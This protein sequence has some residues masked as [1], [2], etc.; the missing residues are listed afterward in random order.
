MTTVK[1]VRFDIWCARCKH[2]KKKETERPC[3]RC[4]SYPV[5]DSSEKPVEYEERGS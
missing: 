2:Q 4:L 1:E 3:A 5:N